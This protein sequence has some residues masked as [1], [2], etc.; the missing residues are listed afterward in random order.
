MTGRVCSHQRCMRSG[1]MGMGW[2]LGTGLVQ[3]YCPDHFAPALTRLDGLLTAARRTAV[4]R[5]AAREP[6][7]VA[8]GR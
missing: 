8:A 7:L 5:Q 6:E 1:E 4:T 3:W 2:G